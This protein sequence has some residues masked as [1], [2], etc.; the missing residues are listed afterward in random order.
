MRPSYIIFLIVLC[1]ISSA[2][3]NSNL[4][5]QLQFADSLMLSKPDSALNLLKKLSI[6]E[7]PNKSAKAMYALLLTQALDKNYIHHQ[8]DS[9]ISIAIDYYKNNKD[10]NLKAKSYFYLGRVYHDNEEYVKATEAYLTTLKFTPTKKNFILQVYNNL[11][12]CY[13]SQEFYVQ[14]IKTYKESY[15]TAELLENKYGILHA[16]RGLASIY[17]IQ[18]DEDSALSYYQTSLA[19]AQSIN[20]STWQTA[21][22]CDIARVYDNLGMH[23]EAKKNIEHALKNAP[24]NTNFSPIYFWKGTILRNL[25]ETDSAICYLSKAKINADIY[26]KASIYQTL[27]EID[28]KRKKYE[29]AILYNDTALVYYDSIQNMVHHTEIN[30]LIKKHSTEMYE[31]RIK[32]QYQKDKLLLIICILLIISLAIFIL[33]YISNRNKKRYVYLQQF[34]MKNQTE[35]AALKE[36]IKTLSQANKIIEQKYA[37]TVNKRFELWHQSLQICVRLFN[38]TTS[39]KK[40]QLIEASKIKKEKGITQE[41]IS[42]IYQEINET[43]TEAMQEFLDQYPNLTQ[44]DLYYCILN[45]LQLSNDTIKTCMR[46]ESQYALNQRKYRIRKQL[47]NQVFSVIFDLKNDKK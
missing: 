46:V 33:M 9:L 12:M 7:M 35:K 27:Y 31:Q 13:E 14:A 37:E 40:I 28:K 23:R 26:A 24:Y 5:P 18:D 10:N 11:A 41:D 34:L 38:T 29:Q 45:Y 6:Q 36:E 20:D 39:Y 4:V 32:N 16:T 43:F 44:E 3:H 2:C 17:A 22:L 21:I 19:I 47:S 30:S 25:E 8:N 15:S 42:L 1:T